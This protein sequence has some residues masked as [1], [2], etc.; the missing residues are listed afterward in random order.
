MGRVEVFLSRVAEVIDR[1][2]ERV[3][4]IVSLVMITLWVLMLALF[5]SFNLN[6]SAPTEHRLV[7]VSPNVRAGDTLGM[8][9]DIRY[10]PG[11]KCSRTTVRTLVDAQG[12]QY[13]VGEDAMSRRARTA[14]VRSKREDADTTIEIRTPAMMN[15]GPARYV[16]SLS[17]VCNPF[18]SWWPIAV[19]VEVPFMVTR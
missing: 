13:F 11:R 19:D 12:I 10:D 5:V 15:P 3:S 14:L 2:P 7:H 17:F 6:R 18:Q 4:R 9:F 8:L 16:A 1:M